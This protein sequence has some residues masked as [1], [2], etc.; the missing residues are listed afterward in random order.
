MS[1]TSKRPPSPSLPASHII[2]SLALKVIKPWLSVSRSSSL[3]DERKKSPPSDL[4]LPDETL[5]TQEQKSKI[6]LTA[7]PKPPPSSIQTEVELVLQRRHAS[8]SSSLLRC[9]Q[10]GPFQRSPS[11]D[12][13]PSCSFQEDVRCQASYL[14]GARQSGFYFGGRRISVSFVRRSLPSFSPIFLLACPLLSSPPLLR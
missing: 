2:L 14:W 13:R 8:D 12:Q 10:E 11:L 6:S 5:G 3:P 4:S 7:T 1:R 9:F